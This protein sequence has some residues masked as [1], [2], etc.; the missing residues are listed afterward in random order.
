MHKASK[1][2]PGHGSRARVAVLQPEASLGSGPASGTSTH[3]L[4]TYWVWARHP[5]LRSFPY[6]ALGHSP[7]FPDEKT[8]AY[9][10]C[11]LSEMTEQ[12]R[13]KRTWN[14]GPRGLLEDLEEKRGQTLSLLRPL[15]PHQGDGGSARDL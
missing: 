4:K 9:S 2:G 11:F 13:A 15:L 8:E 10:G 3:A 7:C 6:C 14:P 1:A 12:K 5:A